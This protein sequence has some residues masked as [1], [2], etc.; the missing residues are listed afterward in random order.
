VHDTRGEL[1]IGRELGEQLLVTAERL[2]DPALILEAHHELWAN[3]SHLGE[4]SSALTHTKRGIELYDPQQHR[5]HAFL[6][7]GHDPGVCALRHAAMIL[8]LLGYQDQAL[9]RSQD[10]LALAQKLSHP[11]SLAFALY[12]S[13]WVHQQRGE[14][15]L[16]QERIEETIGLATEHGMTRWLQQGSVF[17][18]WL[19][20]QEGKVQD[21]ILKMR[22]RSPVASREYSSYVV[23]LTEVYRKVG[24]TDEGLRVITEELARVQKLDLRFYEAELHRIKGE[25]LLAQEGKSEKAKGKTEEVLEA[26]ACFQKALEIAQSQRAK[27]LEL[28]AVMNLS[29]LR[30]QQGKKEV[31]RQML[32][33][34]YG[35][36]TEGFDT[37]DLKEAKAMLEELA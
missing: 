2:Q 13:A 29:R 15:Q 37:A 20:A 14:R 23:L 3:L 33:E 1:N 11:Y 31:A 17:Q 26:E 7:G 10:A 6:Y 21:G 9:Q 4:F 8:C 27:T 18:G 35:W 32:S 16:V 34:I 5:H 22:Q 30:Q 19:L 25:L 28:R 12:Y 24:R 36:F